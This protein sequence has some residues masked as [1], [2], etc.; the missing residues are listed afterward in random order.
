MEQKLDVAKMLDM[1]VLVEIKNVYGNETIYPKNDV[2]R[3]FAEI[4][5]TKTLTRD[6]VNMI[7]DLGYSFLVIKAATL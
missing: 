4:A 1:T 7:K 3:K 2:A 5:G 6:V